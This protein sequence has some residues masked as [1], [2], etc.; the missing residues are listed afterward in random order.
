MTRTMR[1]TPPPRCSP[2]TAHR[3]RHTPNAL[4]A[5]NH[6][7][8]YVNEVLSWAA[9]YTTEAGIGRGGQLAAATAPVATK[10]VSYAL[11]Q[12]GTPT[13]GAA[14]RARRG[15]R[16]LR[17]RQQAAYAAAAGITL[18][19]I[20]QD[21][22]DA[23][24]PVPAGQPLEPGDLRLL[25]H[26]HRPRFDHVGIRHVNGSEMVDAPHT[27]HAKNHSRQRQVPP[28]SLPTYRRTWPAM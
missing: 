22:Y 1:S 28:A 25:R 7:D 26:R 24:P 16:L 9:T 13:S 15:P 21:Q 17:P 18:P 19:R 5:Y 12:L 11:A 3:R 23:G 10:A 20:A 4:Y 2:P 6:A 8:W 27:E 14:R